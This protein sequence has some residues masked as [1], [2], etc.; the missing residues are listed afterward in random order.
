MK[1]FMG[2]KPTSVQ[3]DTRTRQLIIH[4]AQ[5]VARLAAEEVDGV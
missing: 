4:N 5:F 3:V 1:K 2:C